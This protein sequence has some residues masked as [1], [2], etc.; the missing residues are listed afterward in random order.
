MRIWNF[1]HRWLC[2]LH[3]V[4]WNL[5]GA[6]RDCKVEGQWCRL[7]VFVFEEEVS[8]HTD[9]LQIQIQWLMMFQYSVPGPEQRC[10]RGLSVA[11][12]LIAVWPPIILCVGSNSIFCHCWWLQNSTRIYGIE[13]ATGLQKFI[14]C[15]Q[16]REKSMSVS[17]RNRISSI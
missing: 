16:N 6:C 9:F 5:R 1:W 7:Q 12:C 3:A 13:V 17:I 2:S 11:E 10:Y 8:V 15:L 4:V 14:K